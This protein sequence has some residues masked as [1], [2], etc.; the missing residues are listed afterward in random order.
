MAALYVRRGIA[1]EFGTRAG[2]V[3]LKKASFYMY[4]DAGHFQQQNVGDKYLVHDQFIFGHGY[5]VPEPHFLTW[6]AHRHAYCGMHNSRKECLRAANM[7]G[8]LDYIEACL[9]EARESIQQ[10][11]SK[12]RPRR[13]VG[14]RA[15]SVC[16]RCA[17][18]NKTLRMERT[19]GQSVRM[20]NREPLTDQSTNFATDEV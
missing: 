19:I 14:M 13:A 20:R 12:R 1:Q 4:H 15:N 9:Q 2:A 10:Q 18:N 5:A 7:P 3:T 8:R 16:S 6:Q 17:A 11:P